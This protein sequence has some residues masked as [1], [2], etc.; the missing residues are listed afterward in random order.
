MEK[1]FYDKK[2]TEPGLV[3]LYDI[4]PGNKAGLFL[5]PW[6]PHGGIHNLSETA[7]QP[8]TDQLVMRHQP[9]SNEYIVN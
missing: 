6:S 8:C 2:Q 5:Q 7:S 9:V 1:L 4:R 3:A